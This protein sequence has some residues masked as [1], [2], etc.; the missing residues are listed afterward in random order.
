MTRRYFRFE[1]SDCV[2]NAVAGVVFTQL[3]AFLWPDL[4]G[5]I[6]RGE[7]LEISLAEYMAQRL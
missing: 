3:G 5:P 2:P 4:S 6:A 1:V 7:V